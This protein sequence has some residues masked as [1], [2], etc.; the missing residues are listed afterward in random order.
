MVLRPHSGPAVRM[1]EY[2]TLIK[3]ERKIAMKNIR[4]YGIVTGRLTKDP[5]VYNN[6]DGSRKIRITVAAQNQYTDSE[7]NRGS[8]FIPLE[9]FIP[10]KQTGNGP[11]DYL[12]CGDLVSCSYTIQNNN[13]RD[14]N[15][16]MVYGLV[17][18]VDSIALLESKT[19][20]EARLAAKE[21]AA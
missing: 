10:A 5:A 12:D 7:G 13:Y 19:S 17:L 3:K 9:A 6:N 14:R 1:K 2:K 8:Q 4:N 18:Q 20:K 11:Y 21:S 15:G 16:E